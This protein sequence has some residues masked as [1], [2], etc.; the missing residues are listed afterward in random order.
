MAKYRYSTEEEI[1]QKIN[2]YD[3]KKEANFNL[4]CKESETIQRSLTP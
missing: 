3:N 2:K 1:L 4:N